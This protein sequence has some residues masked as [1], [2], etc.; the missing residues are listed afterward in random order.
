MRTLFLS[1]Q[2]Q[3]GLFAAH[4]KR[5]GFL[6][7]RVSWLW[8]KSN[9]SWG[10]TGTDESRKLGLPAVLWA[11]RSSVSNCGLLVPFSMHETMASLAV[12]LQ[13]GTYLRPFTV[14]LLVLTDTVTV[15]KANTKVC[16]CYCLVIKSCPTFCNPM[17]CKLLCS[18]VPGISQA[19]L[20]G[21]V[22]ISF[23]RVSSWPRDW[24][25]VSCIGRQILG[26][27]FTAEPL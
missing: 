18:S 2:S 13:V 9:R 1:L 5:F 16:C 4:S 6:R 8:P 15:N 14:F 10:V 21:W 20:L 27:F 25:H 7:L 3:A 22:A 23:S 26:R 19:R 11:K 17:D 12:S 24:I